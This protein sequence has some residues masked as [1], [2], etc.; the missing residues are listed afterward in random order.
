MTHT[1]GLPQSRGTSGHSTSTDR[2]QLGWDRRLFGE[3]SSGGELLGV[4]PV[5]VGIGAFANNCA[6]C[7]NALNGHAS[8]RIQKFTQNILF[9]LFIRFIVYV[10]PQGCYIYASENE[11]SGTEFRIYI[12]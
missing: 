11:T 1:P 4:Y 3:T 5:D 2:Q 12:R 6:C 9:L 7:I 8:E 10:L